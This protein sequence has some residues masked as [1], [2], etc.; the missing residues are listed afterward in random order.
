MTP[1]TSPASSSLATALFGAAELERAR[2]LQ[3]LGLHVQ[4][5]PDGEERGA[6][7][8]GPDPLRGALDGVEPDEPLA[9]VRQRDRAGREIV[10]A[11]SW[12]IAGDA[13]S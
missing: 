11:G 10:L 1:R 7:R 4:A 5:G 8:D 9:R 2:D 6:V 3:R 12:D 13:G